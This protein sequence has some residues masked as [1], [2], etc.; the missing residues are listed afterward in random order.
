[1]PGD[2]IV[3]VPADGFDPMGD[4]WGFSVNL[5]G[6]NDFTWDRP[7]PSVVPGKPFPVT[8][9][10]KNLRGNDRPLPDGAP[11]VGTVSAEDAN[12]KLT[13]SFTPHPRTETFTFPPN[14]AVKWDVLVPKAPVNMEVLALPSSMVPL[15]GKPY[16]NLDLAKYYDF[17]APGTYRVEF[18]FIKNSPF[19]SE[20]GHLPMDFEV[21]AKE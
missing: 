14:P 20:Y 5:H 12:I 1:V 19:A 7:L 11:A 16:L 21:D 2:Q 15:N 17:S 3:F 4:D 9:G 10:I 18:Q 6:D 8:I 13:V